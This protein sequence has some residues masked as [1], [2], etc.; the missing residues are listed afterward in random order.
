MAEVNV[1]AMMSDIEKLVQRT[2]ARVEA[3]MNEEYVGSAADDLVT[4]TAVGGRTTI[5]IHVLAKRRLDRE[6]LGAA[7]VE[8]VQM[9][10]QRSSEALTTLF[11]DQGLEAFSPRAKA[12]F[13]E[14]MGRLRSQFPF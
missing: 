10:E 9:V 14:T 12:L 3:S 4:A 5:D 6:E 13:T 7:I 1:G 11:D 8:A 2:A